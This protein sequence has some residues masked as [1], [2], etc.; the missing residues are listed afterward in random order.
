M[1]APGT[2]QA[3]LTV[4]DWTQTV[5]F[6]TKMDP[7]IV[8][9]GT[10][11]EEDVTAQVELV[12]K[13]RDALSGARRAATRL[14]TALEERPEDETLLGI[15]KSLLPAIP[16]AGSVWKAEPMI[17]HQLV[18]LYQNLNR[19]DQRPGEDA[20]ERY[21]ELEGALREQVEK[22]DG[23]LGPAPTDAVN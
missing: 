3:R 22:L 23:V 1:A 14:E 7:R 6:D 13:V 17:L 12:L 9:E 2:Y 4:G 5:S 10:V 8:R 11:S 18:Y 16:P 15:R 21:E 20:Y 19:T